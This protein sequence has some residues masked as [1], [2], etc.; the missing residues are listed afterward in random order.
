MTVITTTVRDIAG[1]D[2]RTVFTF[3]VPRLRADTG[4]ITS[5]GYTITAVAGVFTTPDLAPGP[6]IVAVSNSP[7][8]YQITIPDSET[9]VQLGPLI[10]AAIPPENAT[11]GTG[12][13][14]DAGGVARVHALPVAEYAD[15]DHDPATFY[16][17]FE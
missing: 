16:I 6:A 10:D 14:R 1:I 4:V 15:L 8:E 12:Y 17:L 13:V 5:R 2:D 7:D 3:K 11:W 9:P